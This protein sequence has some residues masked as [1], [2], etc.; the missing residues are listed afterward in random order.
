MIRFT[1]LTPRSRLLLAG[2][3]ALLI[4]NLW[5]WWPRDARETGAAG[6]LPRAVRDGELQ[7]HGAQAARGRGP[8]RDLFRPAQAVA[9]RAPVAISAHASVST[10]AQ[11]KGNAAGPAKA[12]PPSP[13]EMARAEIARIK[14][15]GV[16]F[17][18]GR[19]EAYLTHGDMNHIAYEGARI[20]GRYVVEAIGPDSVRIRDE[21]ANVTNE[22]P[23]LGR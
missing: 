5:Q 6:A 9:A 20:E 18:K 1:G 2:V 21:R 23:V 16:V 12:A 10:G 22:I 15:I 17:R 14:V 3:L 8:Q 7:L 19:Y 13:E 4:A 11:G